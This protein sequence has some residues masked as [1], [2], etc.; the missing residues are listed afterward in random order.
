[1]LDDLHRLVLVGL[2]AV[3]HLIVMLHAVVVLHAVMF[4]LIWLGL[5][6]L[7]AVTRLSEHGQRH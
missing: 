6:L 7:H 5:F 4:H 1:M 2:V 3:L